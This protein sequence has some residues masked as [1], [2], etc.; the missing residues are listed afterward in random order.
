MGYPNYD[1]RMDLKSYDA[2]SMLL[3][4]LIYAIDEVANIVYFW[5]DV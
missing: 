1:G 4:I 3:K 5:K 2:R